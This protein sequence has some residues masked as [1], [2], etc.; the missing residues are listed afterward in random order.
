MPAGDRH[1][2][3]E[4]G[5]LRLTS[6]PERHCCRPSIDVLFE[7]AARELGPRSLACLLTGMGA[8]GA[9]GL[10][11][12]RRAGGITIA[13]DEATSR[14][15]GMPGAAVEIGAADQVLPLDQIPHALMA[16]AGC[17]PRGAT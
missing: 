6:D 17:T 10:L 3:L 5:R 12:V 16:A 11:S 2:V 13:Q 14:I 4:A 15:W 8:D 7:S 9:A 1:L